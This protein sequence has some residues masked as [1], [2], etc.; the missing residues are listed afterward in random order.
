[1]R[2]RHFPPALFVFILF[3]CMAMW[4]WKSS[5]RKNYFPLTEGSWWEYTSY[6]LRDRERTT[7]QRRRCIG[8]T[9]VNGKTWMVLTFK[10]DT[11]SRENSLFRWEGKKILKYNTELRRE[12]VQ[13]DFLMKRGDT[14]ATTLD[15]L[16]YT[17][18][19][20]ST[21]TTFTYDQYTYEHTWCLRY[22]TRGSNESNYLF[23]KK[24]IG[25]VGAWLGP[26]YVSYLTD[27]KIQ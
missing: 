14:L 9:L 1:M 11:S 10:H 13:A 4:P 6:D 27:W 21:D 25:L 16:P 24:G 23:F 17:M 26:D 2:S 8:D 22:A 12:D 20:L 3:P 15:T 5:T 18:T 19:V 7:G